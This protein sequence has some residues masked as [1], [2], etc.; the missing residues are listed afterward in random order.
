MT[1]GATFDSSPSKEEFFEKLSNLQD[2]SN[3]DATA[4]ESPC[5]IPPYKD[6]E[7]FTSKSSSQ[8]TFVK[9][10]EVTP[11]HDEK[12]LGILLMLASTL[13]QSWNWLSIK[14]AYILEPEID[15]F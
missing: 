3:G 9:M 8:D 10:K 6:I 5:K 11:P 14:V 7:K 2:S 12:R 4:D 1:V 13:F 15:G